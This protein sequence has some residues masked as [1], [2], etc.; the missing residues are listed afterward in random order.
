VCLHVCLVEP[1][2]VFFCV[3]HAVGSCNVLYEIG[4]RM[5]MASWGD[6]HSFNRCYPVQVFATR[7]RDYR[8]SLFDGSLV[9]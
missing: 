4:N 7:Q 8:G 5:A 6:L 1:V 2:F 3:L 9:G